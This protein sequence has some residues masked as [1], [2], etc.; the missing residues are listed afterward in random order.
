MVVV[1]MWKSQSEEAR[2]ERFINVSAVPWSM[3]AVPS[4]A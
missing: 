1:E 4:M 2:I 3:P